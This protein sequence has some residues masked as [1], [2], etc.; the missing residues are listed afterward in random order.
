MD[1]FFHQWIYEAYYPE[2]AYSWSWVQHGSEYDIT[3]EI[4]QEQTNHIFWMP[5]DVTITTRNG[6]TTLVVWDSLVTQSFNLSISSEPLMLE[7]DK[8]NWI[9]KRMPEIF[10][11]PTFDRGVLLVNGVAF[12][13]YEDEIRHS[14]ENKAFW[15]DVSNQLLG[16][17]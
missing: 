8:N 13:V 12:D 6:E 2:Y 1:K 17:F 10:V 4:N 16:L 11:D 5:I 15:G 14:Y 3:L 9:L 7:L